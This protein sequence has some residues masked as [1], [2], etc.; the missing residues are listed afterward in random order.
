MA[1]LSLKNIT[2]GFGPSLLLDHVNL[3][4]QQEEKIC[5]IGRNGTGKSTLIKLINNDIEPDS[6]EISFF[7][8]ARAAKLDQE[9]PRDLRGSVYEI[10]SKG[11]EQGNIGINSEEWQNRRQVESVLSKMELDPDA[12]FENL[13]AGLKRR[14]LLGRALVS[15]PDLLLLDEPTNHLDIDSI[16]WLEEFLLRHVKTLVFVTHDRIF[17][18]KLAT[19]IIE[20]DRGNLGSWD[21]NYQT[22]LNRRQ[23]Q[24]DAEDNQNR[25]FDKKLAKEEQWIR[26]GIKARRTRNEGRVRALLKM[27]EQRQA[28]RQKTGSVKMLAQEAMKTGKLVMEVSNISYFY[29]DKPVIKDFSTTIM[30]GDR[31][32]IIGPNGSGK[33]TLLNILLGKLSPP[34]GEI[35]HGTHLETAYFDQ[36]RIQLHEDKTVQEN[37]GDG[38][39]NVIINGRPRHIIGWLQDFLFSPERSRS[40]VSVLSGGERN[41]LLLAKMFT[42]P[43]NV[44]VLD[45]PTNDLDAET[46]ELLEELL[47]NYRGTVLL[48]SHDREFLNNVVTNTLVFEGK[49]IVNEY[50]GGYDDWINFRKDN[51][52][53]DIKS[54]KPVKKEKK[55]KPKFQKEK[56]RKL[57]F[58]EKQE[59]EALP[60]L[61]EDLESEQAKI[62]ENMSDPAFYQKQGREIADAKSRLEN[63]EQELETAYER[64]ENLESLNN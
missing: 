10:V 21:C 43:S 47:M 3:E 18:K 30:R 7:K 22:F 42:K 27:R 56:P 8:G 6:G 38:N 53:A 24:L 36:L 29:N 61:I 48:V 52:D 60:K 15:E 45:E 49:G 11:L 23:A 5:L 37:V 31:V 51:E 4:V 13:S 1:L 54:I 57:S 33:T 20:L 14:V 2:L 16:K 58:K 17:L 34:S 32:G 28:R 62:H 25:Q 26:K 12:E 44:L 46:L 50:V 9:V 63:I 64:W 59:L 35:K 40:P 41:R 19:R 39:D 55:S